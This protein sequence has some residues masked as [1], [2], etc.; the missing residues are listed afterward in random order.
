MIAV[1]EQYNAGQGITNIKSARYTVTTGWSAP[2]L[3]E[4]NDTGTAQFPQVAINAS[5]NAIAVWQQS[6]GVYFHI[7]AS[8]YSPGS[9]WSTPERIESY[10]ES[11]GKNPQIA[12]NDSG[13]AV[14][15]WEQHDG[16]LDSIAANIYAPGSGWGTAALID[17]DNSNAAWDPD[18][19]VDPD[20]NA[21]VVWRHNNNTAPTTMTDIRA[22]RYT[23]LGWSTP[24]LIE[25]EDLGAAEKPHVALDD[26]G[27]G[28]A[29]WQQDDSSAI[30][31]MANR[32]TK[33]GGWNPTAFT[34]ES[35][36]QDAASPQIAMSGEGNAYVVWSQSNGSTTNIYA[37]IYVSGIGWG[38][39]TPVQ[40]NSTASGALPQVAVSGS[41]H[42]YAVWQQNDAPFTNS[43]IWS[44]RYVPG[45]GW[46]TAEKL[47]VEDA[48]PA[49]NPQI[50]ADGSGNAVAI[51]Q[52]FNGS[53][54]YIWTDRRITP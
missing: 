48:G 44:N 53:S 13:F 7:W 16:S 41:G 46:E 51:W 5:G 33:A 31:I 28:F 1:W 14:A 42:A 2:E 26:N 36:D 4:T 21:L 25:T 34:L 30:N 15:V 52:Q 29:V 39:A 27:N 50:S 12:M 10:N 11:H 47:D 20:N 32:F 40:T 38:S 49:E 35:S 22:A 54:T 18:V 19:A 3:I 43:D 24:E 9:G 23:S 8:L 6:D 37:N 17:G 45:S